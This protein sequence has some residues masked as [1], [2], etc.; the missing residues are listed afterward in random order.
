[1]FMHDMTSENKY[2]LARRDD[3]ELIDPCLNLYVLVIR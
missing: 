3:A 1:M 2:A